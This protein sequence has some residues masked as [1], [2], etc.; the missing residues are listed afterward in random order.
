MLC[1]Q[2]CGA[3]T[4]EQ[5]QRISDQVHD[6]SARTLEAVGQV[7]NQVHAVA[8]LTTAVAYGIEQMQGSL[9]HQTLVMQCV[10]KHCE[11]IQAGQSEIIAKQEE[12]MDKLNSIDAKVDAIYMSIKASIQTQPMKKTMRVVAMLA[13]HMNDHLE[14]PCKPKFLCTP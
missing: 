2:K 7:S 11:N 10:M 13:H 14:H 5:V 9:Q 1:L 4:Q 8:M 12:L 3:N 6:S